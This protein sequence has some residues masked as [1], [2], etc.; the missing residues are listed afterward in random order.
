MV[1]IELWPTE[2][3]KNMESKVCKRIVLA[4]PYIFSL[5]HNCMCEYLETWWELRPLN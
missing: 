5:C 2:A 1:R 4:P 3:L